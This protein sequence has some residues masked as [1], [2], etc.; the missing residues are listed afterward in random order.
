MGLPQVFAGSRAYADG[1]HHPV[2]SMGN[3]DGLH[4]GHRMLVARLVERATERGAPACVYTF[5]PPPRVV[6]A[7]SQHGP[8]IQTWPDTVRIMGELGVGQT[9]G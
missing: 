9:S 1:G 8:R 6:L 5:D 7:P 3:F 4:L 2:L